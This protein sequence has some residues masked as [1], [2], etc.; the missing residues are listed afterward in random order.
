[1]IAALGML[2]CADKN[3]PEQN[4]GNESGG[5]TNSNE[6][7]CDQY[8]FEFDV[9]ETITKTILLTA[10]GAWNATTDVDWISINPKNGIGDAYVKVS[11][12]AGSQGN[13][14]V[15]FSTE[16]ASAKVTF[17]R[18][19]KWPN[20]FTIGKNKKVYFSKGNLQYQPST[21]KWRFA[22]NPWEFIGEDNK[23][24]SSSYTGWIDLFGW[25]TG[26][27]PTKTSTT[28]S[29]YSYFADWGM[30]VG[31]MRTLSEGEWRYLIDTREN[32]GK[33]RGKAK[34]CGIYGYVFLPDGWSVPTG[35]SFNPYAADWATNTYQ[36]SDWN[37]M[38]EAGA[39]FLP[40]YNYGR[41]GTSVELSHS[42]YA[43]GYYWS[44]SAN[45]NNNGCCF[46]IS[47]VGVGIGSQPKSV[48]LFVRL[49]ED[50]K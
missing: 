37:V 42:L 31:G 33:L 8:V 5:S 39:C 6:I 21:H 12:K 22:E 46:S 10:N 18:I 1:M 48:G 43:D 27:N 36:K 40:W 45:G 23:N 11:T 30:Y 24:I 26:S 34:V 14:Y 44:A 47:S 16:K 2:A 20:S 41:I 32:A 29:D 9:A 25:G 38:K 4:D 49:V 28:D 17:K 35:M 13:G 7:S 19:D 15:I 3:V 50:I